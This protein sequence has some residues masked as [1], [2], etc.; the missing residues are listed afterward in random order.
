MPA[1]FEKRLMAQAAKKGFGK[2]RAARYVYGFMNKRGLM[3]GN[4]ITDKGRA[5]EAKHKAKYRKRSA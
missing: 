1:F 3:S 2:K 4:K 5:M